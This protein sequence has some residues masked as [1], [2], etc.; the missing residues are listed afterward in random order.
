MYKRLLPL[1]LATFAV[2]TDGFVIA[3]LLPAIADDLDVS[4]PTAGQLVTVFALTLAV[5]APVLGWATSALD[6]RTALLLA[7]GVFVI[8]NAATAMAGSYG[9]VMGARVVTAAGAGIIT[10]TA[11]S[12]A[13]AVTPPERRGRALAF[14]LGGLTLSSAI[15]LPLGTLIG[16]GDWHLTLWAVA[17]LGV[18]AALGIA[19]GIPRITLP[20][21]TF[22]ARLAPLKDRWVLGVLTVTMLALTGTYL[23]Y[24][25]IAAALDDVTGG[26]EATLT[27]VLFVYGLGVLGGNLLAGRLSDGHRPER[28]LLGSLAAAIIV[29]AV[30]RAAVET[31]PTAFVWTAALGLC[32]GVPVVPQQHRLVA[33]APSATPV[34]LGLNASAI[35]VGVALGG[36]LGGLA[37]QAVSPMWLGIPAAVVTAVALLL[38]MASARRTGG[39]DPAAEPDLAGAPGARANYSHG[40]GT[41]PR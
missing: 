40:S 10:S 1:A 38:A 6:R 20:A 35:Y 33:H 19:F 2:G 37:Q 14:V 28:V 29:L 34:L 17:A 13:V 26:S 12:A 9:A 4:V 15:G 31:L 27:A 5:A 24:T 16:R 7:L 21:A 39:Q 23:L 32:A 3:G 30:G 25:Y 36:A 22:R 8:G 41:S 18:V 11:A